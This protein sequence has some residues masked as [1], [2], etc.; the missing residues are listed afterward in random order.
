MLGKHRS[1][2]TLSIGRR[3]GL[4]QREVHGTSLSE[5]FLLG[6][7][8][9]ELGLQLS[10]DVGLNFTHVNRRGSISSDVVQTASSRVLGGLQFSLLLGFLLLLP[11]G[12]LFGLFLSNTLLILLLSLSQLLLLSHSGSVTFLGSSL[13]SRGLFDH[14]T[15][16]SAFAS[17]LNQFVLLRRSVLHR[18]S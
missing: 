7:T 9:V 12:S 1:D 17:F 11:L 18:G 5:Q 6:S 2:D 10:L 15:K 14:S 4:S 8:R 16:D 3:L 13:R